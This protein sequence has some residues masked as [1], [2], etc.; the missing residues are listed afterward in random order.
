[1]CKE[2]FCGSICGDTLRCMITSDNAHAQLGNH[3]FFSGLYVSAR[4]SMDMSKWH[5]RALRLGLHVSG[6]TGT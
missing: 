3:M 6:A 1:M 2:L 4:I 5:R